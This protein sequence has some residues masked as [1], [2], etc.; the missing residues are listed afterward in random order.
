MRWGWTRDPAWISGE[1]ALGGNEYVL[2]L[3]NEHWHQMMRD[4]EW[5]QGARKDG[6]VDDDG[7]TGKGIAKLEK[8]ST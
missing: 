8:F 4:R 6:L 1:S 2:F 3:K 7:W 5:W